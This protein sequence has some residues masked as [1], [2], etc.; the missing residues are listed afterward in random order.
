MSDD[1]FQPA[2]K[3]LQLDIARFV[4]P[5]LWGCQSRYRLIIQRYPQIAHKT[6]DLIFRP[7]IVIVK[8]L[9]S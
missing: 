1:V 6:P 3:A 5:G 9:G 8:V 4:L 7:V 2:D